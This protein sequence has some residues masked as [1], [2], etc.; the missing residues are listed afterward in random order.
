MLLIYKPGTT[1][2]RTVF[3]LRERNANTRKMTSPLPDLEGILRRVA[4]HKYV[5]SLDGCDA[6]EQIRI[7][8]EHIDRTAVT[9]PNGNLYRCLFIRLF[10]LNFLE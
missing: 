6:Y 3:D 1:L 2:L 10:V 5:S 9:T 7:I 8:P 4:K